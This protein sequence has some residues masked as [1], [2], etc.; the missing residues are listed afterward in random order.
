MSVSAYLRSNEASSKVQRQQFSTRSSRHPPINESSQ[1]SS[2]EVVHV[3]LG[4]RSYNIQIGAGL[5]GDLETSFQQLIDNCIY[6]D[7]A[8]IITDKNVANEYLG[9]VQEQLEHCFERLDTITVEP[10]EKSKSVDHSNELWNQLVQFNTDRKSTIIA[11]G[12]GVVGDLA[13]FAAA[14][15]ARGINFV[16][17]PTTLLAQVDS[18]VGGKVGINLPTAKNIVGSF[19]QPKFVVIDPTALNTLS[20]REYQSGLAEVIKYGVIMDADFFAFLEE[21]VD[22]INAR[23]PKTLAK[24]IKRCCEL[25][26]EVVQA[27]ETEQSGRRAILNYGHTYGHA[28]E[29]ISGYGKFT[30]G[31]AIAIGMNCAARLAISLGMCNKEV[32]ERQT[33]LMT[34][35]GLPSECPRESHSELLNAMKRDK[36]VAQGI[37]YLV[38][39]TK[40]GHVEVTESPDDEQLLQSLMEQ[41]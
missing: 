20:D 13:G 31:E 22:A 21:S 29:A 17:I 32:L 5:L 37:L 6:S 33:A 38:L 26:T 36:K 14:T 12:G 19:W 16:Q 24:I 7:H 18:S 11:L 3:G 39:P 27:D 41:K 2:Y 1:L 23:D 34:A 40:I 28:I 8:I 10:G 15:F 35:V 30:H 4:D 25:K 9:Q